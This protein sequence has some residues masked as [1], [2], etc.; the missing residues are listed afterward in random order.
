MLVTDAEREGKLSP[1][2]PVAEHHVTLT[3]SPFTSAEPFYF[4]PSFRSVATSQR[5][6]AAFSAPARLSFLQLDESQVC[7]SSSA[8]IPFPWLRSTLLSASL[9]PGLG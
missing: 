3:Q 8:A 2:V 7:Q 4:G 5:L 9:R 1:V 6:E